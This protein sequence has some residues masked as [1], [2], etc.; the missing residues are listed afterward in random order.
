MMTL[1][2]SI[3]SRV[4]EGKIKRFDGTGRPGESFA[5]REYFQ[6]YGFSSRPLEGAEGIMIKQGNNIVLLA[7]DDRRYR[8]QLEAGEVALYTDE[9]DYV[10]MKRGRVVEISTGTLRVKASEKV[11]FETPLVEAAGDVQVKK[12]L[13]VA[14]NITA[15][16]NI[17]DSGEAGVSM[18]AMREKYNGHRHPK[19]STG[20]TEEPRTGDKME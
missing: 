10:H 4:V 5:D 9:G 15:Q 20:T 14:Q 12:N 6:H 13:A 1:I 17:T 19:G 8:I 7:S 3:L 2:R 18:A 11:S 16:G